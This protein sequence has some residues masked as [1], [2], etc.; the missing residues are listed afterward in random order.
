M[1]AL[2]EIRSRIAEIQHEYRNVESLPQSREAIRAALNAAI[3]DLAARG[4]RQI[5][6][7]IATKQYGDVLM[8]TQP[9]AAAIHAA[10]YQDEIA[11]R[12]QQFIDELPE[13][14]RARDKT[15]RIAELDADL[16]AAENEEMDAI[17]EIEQAGLPVTWRGDMSVDVL[18]RMPAAA[19][20]LEGLNP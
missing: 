6:H 13:G 15:L 19:V 3:V 9:A 11:A 17:L 1:N 14:I 18:L 12:L 8:P 20:P 2:I 16:A 7:L 4:T 5:R 10:L